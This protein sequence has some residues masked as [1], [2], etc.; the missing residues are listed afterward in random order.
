M[1]GAAA[2]SRFEAAHAGNYFYGVAGVSARGESALRVSAQI[3]VAAGQEV[4]LTV[5]GA[6]GSETGYAIY[7]SRRNGTSNPADMRLLRR[8]PRV[9][10]MATEFRDRNLDI[11]GTTSAYML[12]MTKGDTAIT[13]R[14]LLPM[15]RFELFPTNAAVKPWAQLLFGYLRMTK[16]RH[17]VVFRNILP[18]S[19]LWRPF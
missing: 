15:F 19:A 12:N 5:T 11:P 6:G 10:G 13:W 7:R 17:H 4:V 2:G 16:R 14:Q 9:V 18:V 3:A 8:V 1:P